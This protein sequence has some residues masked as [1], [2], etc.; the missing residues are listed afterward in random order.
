VFEVSGLAKPYEILAILGA[1]GSGKTTLLNALNLRNRGEL[2]VEGDVKVNGKLI[3]MLEEIS[4][5]SG[6]VQQNDLFIGNLQVKEHL[7]FQVQ[8]DNG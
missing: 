3:G 1:S 7:I 6:Y 4:S 2:K 5:M 8:F